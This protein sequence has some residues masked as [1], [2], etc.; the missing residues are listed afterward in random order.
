MRATVSRMEPATLDSL[1]LLKIWLLILSATQA[2]AALVTVLTYFRRSPPLDKVLADLA[3]DWKEQLNHY[4]PHEHLTR[5][6]HVVDRRISGLADN[7]ARLGELSS[8]KDSLDSLRGDIAAIRTETGRQI[9]D[10]NRG[11]GA[12]TAAASAATAAAEAATHAAQA[13]MT[14]AAQGKGK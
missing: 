10:L 1:F 12:A 14:L 8:L 9:I 4:V 7:T 6:L 2:G 5:E 3:A 13:A 11:I